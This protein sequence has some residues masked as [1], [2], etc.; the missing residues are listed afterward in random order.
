LAKSILSRFS[1]LHALGIAHRDITKRTLWVLEP[2]RVILSTFA[3]ARIP[4]AQ[5]VGVHRI[6]LE[7]GSI[8]LPEDEGV[9][10]HA[11]SSEPFVRDVF[12]LGVLVYEML[13]GRELER[14][15]D[16]PVYDSTLTLNVPAL[17]PWYAKAMDLDPE[18]RYRNASEALD[19]LNACLAV[20]AGPDVC[21]EDF[22]GY[23]TDAG[24]MTLMAKRVISSVPTKMVYESEQNGDRVLVKCWPQLKFDPKYLARNLRLLAF[25]Q[26]ARSLRQ[27]GFNA[28]PE[29][30]DFGLNTFGLMLVTRWTEGQTL[31][32]WLSASPDGRQRALVAHALLNA[33]R[34]LHILGLSHGDVKAD[35]V[36]VPQTLEDELPRVVLVDIPDLS[37]DGDDGITVGM[38]PQA[39]ESALSCPSFFVFQGPMVSIETGRTRSE[40]D[41]EAGVHSRVQ[42]AGR[43]ARPSGGHRGRCQGTGA[44]RAD[45]AQ[46]GEGDR[47]R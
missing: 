27:S 29:V 17:A 19:A 26:K 35:N 40:E 7:T 8:E 14:L 15:N 25:L 32:E 42:G 36:V 16:V 10:A 6:E 1:K 43:L 39:L 23:E 11:R 37:A 21:A 22:E 13:E 5:T 44:G 33:V 24:P 20:D 34:R 9:A 12:L 30:L 28:A 46:L 2:A 38:V 41:T 4:Q 45:A 47:S 18:A 31:T 3:A